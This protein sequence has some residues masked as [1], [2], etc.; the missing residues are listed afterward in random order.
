MLDRA[1]P[2]GDDQGRA[3]FEQAVERLAIRPSVFVSTRKSLIED[4][5]RGL[6]ARARAKLTNAVAPR[7]CRAAFSYVGIDAVAKAIEQRTKPHLTQCSFDAG[8]A[9]ILI[10]QTHV[11]FQRAGNKNGS[12]KTIPNCFRSW[13]TS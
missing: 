6:C 4:Q 9:D 11:G 1:Q 13:C 5:E 12:C 10:A 7:K 2:V 8:P 3:A